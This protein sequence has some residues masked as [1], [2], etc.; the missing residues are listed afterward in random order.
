MAIVENPFYKD[1]VGHAVKLMKAEGLKVK[2]NLTQ[3]LQYIKIGLDKSLSKRGD[4]ALSSAEHKSTLALKNRLTSWL[5]IKN[6]QYGKARTTFAEDSVVPN[7]QTIGK[8]LRDKLVKPGEDVGEDIAEG[9]GE[10]GGLM[11]TKQNRGAYEAALRN[12]AQTIKKGSGESVYKTL[13]DALTPEQMAATKAVSDNLKR[14]ADYE[15]ISTAGGPKAMGIIE[16]Q[17]TTLPQV[18]MFNPKY[19]V[20]RSLSARLSG[21]VQGKSIK[22]LAE[23]IANPARAAEI[24]KL[25]PQQDL[26]LITATIREVGRAG[27]LAAPQITKAGDF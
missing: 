18:G 17:S 13:D 16:G 4:D 10:T 1:Q 27:T 5:D 19:S 3:F 20:L 14:R 8:V 7:Q 26:P 12:E 15:T 25:I 9:I 22:L 2:D 11:V 21:R 6:P 23:V 24:M